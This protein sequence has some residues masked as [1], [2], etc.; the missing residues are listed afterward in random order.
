MSTAE[1]AVNEQPLTVGQ[2]RAAL[3]GLPDDAQAFVGVSGLGPDFAITHVWQSE[4]IAWGDDD[5]RRGDPTVI[6]AEFHCYAGD[7]SAQREWGERFLRAWSTNVLD[8]A[9]AVERV[10]QAASRAG[11]S[12]RYPPGEVS[13]G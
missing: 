2:I 5:W 3:D 9:D 1:I 8:S 4:Q 7:E 11:R 13:D 6:G 12:L 10:V